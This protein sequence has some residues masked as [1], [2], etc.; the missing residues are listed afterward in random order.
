MCVLILSF[1]FWLGRS[2][3]LRFK[4]LHVVF[5]YLQG[6]YIYVRVYY[7]FIYIS[8]FTRFIPSNDCTKKIQNL[9]TITE[10]CYLRTQMELTPSTLLGRTKADVI[11]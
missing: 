7:V 6:I 1:R 4:D 5:V 3:N 9:S 10:A 11:N 8:I 2:Q